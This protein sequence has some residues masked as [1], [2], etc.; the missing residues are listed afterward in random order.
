MSFEYTLSVL[1]NLEKQTRQEIERLGGNPA[2]EKLM[3]LLHA[4]PA[5]FA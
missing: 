3:D 2:L 4:D 5:K 1:E